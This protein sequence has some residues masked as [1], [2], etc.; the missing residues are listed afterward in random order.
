[1]CVTGHPCMDKAAHYFGI[2]VVKVPYNPVTYQ[3]DIDAT[4]KAVN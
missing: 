4:A 3:M 2:K 1:M